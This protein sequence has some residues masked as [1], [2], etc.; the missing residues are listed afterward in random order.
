MLNCG[1]IAA[2]QL[3]KP[4]DFPLEVAAWYAVPRDSY[5]R[6]GD[7]FKVDGTQ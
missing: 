3:P 7:W 4:I 1:A 6:I 2:M 5:P